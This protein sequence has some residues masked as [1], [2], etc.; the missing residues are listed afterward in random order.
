MVHES[1][2][3]VCLRPTRGPRGFEELGTL[4]EQVVVNCEALLVRLLADEH[5]ERLG[6]V[7]VVSVNETVSLSQNCVREVVGREYLPRALSRWRTVSVCH[8]VAVL[9][10][11]WCCYPIWR[12][13]IQRKPGSVRMDGNGDFYLLVWMIRAFAFTHNPLGGV[14]QVVPPYDVL[15]L[16]LS[17]TRCRC[18]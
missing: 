5:V 2:G 4:N 8:V 13:R 11:R 18:A 10:V 16:S 3:L 9:L 14:P 7:I 6:Q 15:S 1:G 17:S 12:S